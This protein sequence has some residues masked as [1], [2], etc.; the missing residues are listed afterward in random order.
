MLPTSA[1]ICRAVVDRQV[2]RGVAADRHE[3]GV[4]DREL[5]GEAV[6]QV[7][8]DGQRDVDADQVDD[9]R[10]VRVDLEVAEPVLEDLVEP[11]R[12]SPS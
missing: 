9:A 12:E 8:A 2:G 3:S 11:E 4:A 10:V 7:Q 6:D 5:P 1:A